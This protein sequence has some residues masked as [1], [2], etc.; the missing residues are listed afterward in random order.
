MTADSTPTVVEALRHAEF[1]L[2]GAVPGRDEIERATI[3]ADHLRVI[4]QA[5]QLHGGGESRS[6]FA[7]G[8]VDTLPEAWCI[9][10][11]EATDWMV[12]EARRYLFAGNSETNIEMAYKAMLDAAPYRQALSGG[13]EAKPTSE[14]AS[15]PTL[16]GPTREEVARIV[17]VVAANGSL[18]GWAVDQLVALLKSA[19]PSDVEAPR[20]S[21]EG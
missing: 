8:S 18:C 5:L 7:S 19:P 6:D 2:K 20:Q 4:V 12:K 10:P 15:N 3:Y 1:A 13:G 17:G 11:A 14:T 16:Q 21:G 9:A